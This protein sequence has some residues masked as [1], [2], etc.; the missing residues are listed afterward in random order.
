MAGHLLGDF[1]LAAVLQIGGDAG[2]TEAVGADLGFEPCSARSLLDHHVYIG[3]GQGSAVRQSAIAQG[4]EEGSLVD[5]WWKA[6]ACAADV[7]KQH[8]ITK[9]PIDP[10]R[11]ADAKDIVHQENPSLD[12]GVSGCLMRV[13]DQFG[14][15]YSTRFPSNGFR[16]FTVGHELGHYF[17][18]GHP[19]HLFKD[20]CTLHTSTSGF[21]S[22]DRYEQEADAFAASLLMPKPLFHDAAATVGNGLD[23]VIALATLCEMSLTSTAIRY[24][25]LIAEPVAIVL[26]MNRKVLFSIMS[27]MLRTQR[28]LT[29]LKKGN[30]IPSSTLTFQFA[31]D[32]SNIQYARTASGYSTLEDWFDGSD[33]EVREEVMGLGEYGRTLTVL[34]AES[35]PDQEEVVARSDGREDDEA[36]SLLPSQRFY[37]KSRY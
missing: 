26:S 19:E 2:R 21:V 9:L 7:L 20:G 13:G 17:L 25:R 31:G 35:L 24:A 15:M 11:I 32:S 8:N 14:I 12:A 30:G 18:E 36:E 33:T 3:L 1:K 27:P 6:E 23:A 37:R 5:P 4:R 28:N 10:F 34:R 16:R 29:W 22:D